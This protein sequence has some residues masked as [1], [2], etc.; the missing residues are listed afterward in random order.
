MLS[1]VSIRTRAPGSTVST[2]GCSGP[3]AY[4]RPADRWSSSGPAGAAVV[5]RPFKTGSTTRPRSSGRQ[6]GPGDRLTEVLERVVEI[7]LLAPGVACQQVDAAD[8]RPPEDH[9]RRP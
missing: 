8:D 3:S 7:D 2:G 6:A 9:V 5:A 1:S 4:S